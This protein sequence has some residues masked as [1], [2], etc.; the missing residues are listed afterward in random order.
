MMY[1]YGLNPQ[2]DDVARELVPTLATLW[3]NQKWHRRRFVSSSSGELG[4]MTVLKKHAK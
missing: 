2:C 1:S 4:G 3:S